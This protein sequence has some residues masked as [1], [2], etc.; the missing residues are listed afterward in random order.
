MLKCWNVLSPFTKMYFQPFDLIYVW[1]LLNCRFKYRIMCGFHWDCCRHRRTYTD[2]SM[3]EGYM[4]KQFFKYK[5]KQNNFANVRHVQ[6][7]TTLNFW[8]IP[9]RYHFYGTESRTNNIHTD[10]QIQ[11]IFLDFSDVYY[12]GVHVCS[13]SSD[14]IWIGHIWHVYFASAKIK[15]FYSKWFYFHL[16]CLNKK[17][18]QKN[19]CGESVFVCVWNNKRAGKRCFSMYFIKT[20]KSKTPQP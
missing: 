20:R 5:T 14:V 9:W 12:T 15:R 2:C 4:L 13:T 7:N 1:I 17:G 8:R 3:S 16:K 18:K 11:H 19:W 10:T 6:Q